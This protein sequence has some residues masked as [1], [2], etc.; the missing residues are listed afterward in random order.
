M[1]AHDELP[2][3]VDNPSQTLAELTLSGEGLERGVRRARDLMHRVRRE[4]AAV[5]DG[6]SGA[7]ASIH[8]ADLI[9]KVG[10]VDL[11][12]GRPACRAGAQRRFRF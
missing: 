3:I 7:A 11:R 9:Q 12:S 6:I 2:L 4:L 1:M 5:P 8:L 10:L